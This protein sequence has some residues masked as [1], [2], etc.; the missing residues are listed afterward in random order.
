MGKADF[1]LER[2]GKRDGWVAEAGL[3]RPSE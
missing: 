2:E 1:F 3:P